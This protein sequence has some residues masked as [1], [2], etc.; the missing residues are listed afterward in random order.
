[1]S[2]SSVQSISGHKHH[3][4]DR[5]HG[6]TASVVLQIFL[7]QSLLFLWPLSIPSTPPFL[8]NS[9][10]RLFF[11]QSRPPSEFFSQVVINKNPC[12][13]GRYSRDRAE[14]MESIT[15]FDWVTPR[16]SS[17]SKQLLDF[18]SHSDLPLLP[19][20]CFPLHKTLLLILPLTLHP[21][22]SLLNG[23]SLPHPFLSSLFVFAVLFFFQLLLFTHFCTVEHALKCRLFQVA[24]K[25]CLKTCNF[26]IQLQ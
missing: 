21:C 3:L 25:T 19:F 10:P 13:R 18:H 12:E 7:L 20:L 17:R 11:S 14:G 2:F 1:M 5:S 4:S 26:P 15:R 23:L 16:L 8:F 24:L 9:L 22:P 6:P